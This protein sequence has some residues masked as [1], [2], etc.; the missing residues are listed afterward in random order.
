[1]LEAK[2]SEG[3]PKTSRKRLC[4]RLGWLAAAVG[5]AALLLTNI[6][7]LRQ[8]AENVFFPD[9]GLSIS[10]A[11][12]S[13]SSPDP[14]ARGNAYRIKMRV[15]KSHVDFG[16]ECKTI[17]ASEQT[18]EIISEGFSLPI[19]PTDLKTTDYFWANYTA[20]KGDLKTA[21][22][23]IRCGNVQTEWVPAH[24]SPWAVFY[25]IDP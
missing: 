3:P 6:G 14:T 5:S 25:Q 22:V 9:P 4:G 8:A 7:K 13:L 19:Y 18:P 15:K 20:L 12:V 2:Q 17:F 23:R 1:M 11:E 16:R 24:F 21:K 10:E